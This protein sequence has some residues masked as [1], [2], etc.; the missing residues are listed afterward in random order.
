MSTQAPQLALPL[1]KPQYQWGGR[2]PGAGRKALPPERRK[3]LPH[4]SRPFHDRNHPLHVTMR[5]VR[6]IPSLRCTELARV[7]GGVLRKQKQRP[8]FRVVHVSIQPNHLHL[9]V[10]AL[11]RDTLGRGLQTLASGIARALNRHLGR[12]GRV[13]ADRYHAGALTTPKATRNAIVYVLTNYKHHR[14]ERFAFDPWSSALWFDGWTH[15]P[16]ATERP[17][18][19][20]EPTTWLLRTGWRRYG[21]IDPAEA[22]A[23]VPA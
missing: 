7:V 15:A 3:G 4:R 14:R 5:L 2:R 10:E 8:G 19:A 12:K 6:G 13:F 9:I 20:A 22:P 11:G 16:P 21:K 18:P 17:P 1:P 23:D